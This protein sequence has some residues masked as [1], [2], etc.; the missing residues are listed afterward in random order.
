M[1]GGDFGS[2]AAAFM[3][4]PL[5]IGVFLAGGAFFSAVFFGACATLGSE[6]VQRPVPAPLVLTLPWMR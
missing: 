2:R 4:L 6:W 1:M 3:L 5:S